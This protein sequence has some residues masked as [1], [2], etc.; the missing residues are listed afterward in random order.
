MKTVLPLAYS[1]ANCVLPT[2]LTHDEDLKRDLF[3]CTI[4]YSEKCG[5]AMAKTIKMLMLS[6]VFYRQLLFCLKHESLFNITC[7]HYISYSKMFYKIVFL[8]KPMNNFRKWMWRKKFL[9]TRFFSEP[10]A[11]RKISF[12]NMWC[13]FVFFQVLF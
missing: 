9:V 7:S 5:R 13:V 12:L 4:L 10:R 6:L 11:C 2:F 8:K 1:E 3:H